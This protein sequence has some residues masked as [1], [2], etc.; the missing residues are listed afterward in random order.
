M[1]WY[2]FMHFGE[3]RYQSEHTIAFASV[4]THNQFCL[5]NGADV[6]NRHAPVIKLPAAASRDQHLELLGLLNS[7]T[8]CFWMK[9]VFHNKGS[10]VDQHGARQRTDAFEDFHEFTGTGLQQFPLPADRPLVLP[11]LLDELVGHRAGFL[12]A[13][14]LKLGVPTPKALEMARTGAAAVLGLMIAAQEDLDWQCYRLY[15]LI[16]EELRYADG[17][18]PA[19][20]LGQRAFEIV[21]ARKM[22]AG[23][24]ETTWFERHGST[25]ITEIPADWPEAYSQIVRRRIEIIESDKNIALIERPEYK[26]RWNTEP[27]DQMQERA[28]REWLLDRLEGWPLEQKSDEA[29]KR[30]S[31][32]GKTPRSL[33]W[34]EREPRLMSVAQLVERVR[35]DKLFCQVAAL[36]RGREDFDMTKL[37]ADLV[38]DEAVPFLPVLRYK[39]SG[40]RNRRVWEQVWELQRQEDAINGQIAAAGN[41]QS[42][43]E[44]LKSKIPDLP[45]IPVP[46]KYKSADMLSG[47]MWRLR[48]KLDVPK[49]RFVSY[50]HCQRDADPTLTITWAGFDHLQQLQGVAAYYMDMKEREGWPADRRVPLLAGMLELL[51]WVLQWHN[52]VDPVHQLRMGDYYRDFINDEVR[53]MGRTVEQIKAWTPPARNGGRRRQ[54]RVTNDGQAV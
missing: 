7:S 51:P 29:T 41:D 23:Q 8:A 39:E 5:R 22:A 3:D 36:Y 20:R 6:L 31:D 21:L 49:E 40:L 12:P 24:I 42:K 48:G 34:N 47:P 35:A 10:T 43:I 9:Q 32:E 17:V 37:V 18:M 52:D 14:V 38:E 50:P 1:A 28:L 54:R 16:D 33:I 44:N 45:S 46:P 25:P 27:W 15:G 53:E 11:R 30:L 2:A 13:A 4:A 19:I 26:R